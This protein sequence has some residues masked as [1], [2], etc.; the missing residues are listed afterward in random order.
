VWIIGAGVCLGWD[1]VRFLG[2]GNAFG[3][4]V[5]A[6]GGFIHLHWVEILVRLFF[7]NFYLFSWGLYF[8]YFNSS[9]DFI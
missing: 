6:L 7:F 5:L 9:F 8:D 3:V 4:G 2:L 1:C